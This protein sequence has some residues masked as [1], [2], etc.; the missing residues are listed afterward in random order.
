MSIKDQIRN[1]NTMEELNH[2]NT[3]ADLAE[4]M[5]PKTF[6]QCKR[7]TKIKYTELKGGK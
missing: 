4:F 3:K 2:A 1:A 7:L 5:S 6:R